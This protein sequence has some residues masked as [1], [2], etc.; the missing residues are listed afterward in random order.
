M[1]RKPNSIML[2]DDDANDNFFHER[3][4]KKAELEIV[5]ITK[6]TG[7]DALEYLKLKKDKNNPQPDLIFLDI[8]MPGMNGFEFLEEFKLLDKEIQNQ[9]IIIMLSTSDNASE[10]LRAKAYSFVLDFLVKK[11]SVFLIA[12]GS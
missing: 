8:N 5:V 3:E 2:V 11:K 4:I 9:T 12:I 6:D 1:N 10:V 7:M